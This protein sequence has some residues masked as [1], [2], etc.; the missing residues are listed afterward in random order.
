MSWRKEIRLI[1]HF[2][3]EFDFRCPDMEI[4]FKIQYVEVLM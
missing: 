2:P 3:I 4:L 1:L